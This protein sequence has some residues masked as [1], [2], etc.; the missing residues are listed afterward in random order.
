[1]L[2]LA[3]ADD[4]QDPESN[5]RGWQTAFPNGKLLVVRGGAHGVIAD[6]CVSLVVAQFVADGSARGLDTTCVG[7]FAP[8]P[9]VISSP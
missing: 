8:P 4:P 9:F 7:R 1:V 2:F 3:G 5:L 6:G